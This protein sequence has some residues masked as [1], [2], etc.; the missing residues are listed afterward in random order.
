MSPIVLGIDVGSTTVKLVVLDPEG[1]I[2]AHRYVR[3]NGQPRETLL[4]AGRILGERFRGAAVLAA[5]LTG[6]GGSAVAHLVGGLHTN[7]LVAQ[8]RAVG[9]LHPEA[10]TVI[11]IGGQDSKLLSVEWDTA[12]GQMALTDFAM[13]ALCAAGT[14]SFLDQ[15]AERLGIA[16]DGEFAG[17]ALASRRPARIAGRCTVF[18]KSD[19]IH[20]QQE[21][22]PLADIL[23]GLCQALA[24]NF[25]S[26]IGKGKRFGPPSSLRVAWP[27][28]L[29]WRRP[30]RRSS[31]WRQA[32]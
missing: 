3:A 5:G 31:A 11:E 21:G 9:V 19:M 22:C 20:L 23:A 13:N 4:E 18:A 16:I 15:Q 1:R 7:E 2:L 24:R 25:R 30:S 26:V 14:G 27:G 28:T 29:R 17:L 10:R 32:S 6:S 12:S 8:T